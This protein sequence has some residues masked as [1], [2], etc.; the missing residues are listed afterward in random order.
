MGW[1]RGRQTTTEVQAGAST[2]NSGNE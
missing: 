1:Q 2:A